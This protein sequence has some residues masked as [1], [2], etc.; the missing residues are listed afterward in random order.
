MFDMMKALSKLN[1]IKAEMAK[2]KAGLKDI[3]IS[4]YSPDYLVKVTATADKSIQ[5]IEI[6]PNLFNET[7]KADLEEKLTETINA[8]LD[9]ASVR[10]KAE[11][12]EKMKGK[13]PDLPGLDLKNLLS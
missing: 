2:V 1:D 7:G 8:V 12:E 5:K 13:I 11:I 9:K 6:S 4:E 10:A 3:E